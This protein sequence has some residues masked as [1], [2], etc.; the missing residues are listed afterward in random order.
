MEQTL[1]WA[2]LIAVLAAIASGRF[3]IDIIALTGLLLLGLSGI[4]PP[5]IVFSGFGNPALV[6]IITVFLISQ[7][8]INSGLLRGLGQALA[9]RAKSLRGQIISVA[10]VSA[11][12]ST[13]MNNVGAVGLML[14]TAVRMAQRTGQGPGVFGLPLAMFS[15][16]GGTITLV[17]VMVTAIIVGGLGMQVLRK[18]AKPVKSGE[19]LKISYKELKKWSIPGA[20]IFGLGWGISGA[21]PG[22]VLAQIGE[23]KLFGLFTFAGMIFGTYIYARLKE[24]NSEL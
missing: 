19:P 6:T 2:V 15:I 23:G 5:D 4:A 3:R 1:S 12:L 13:I 20:L 8:L 9:R 22:T 11:L 7:G 16:L 18:F 14:P 24:N 21:C 17:G 10:A